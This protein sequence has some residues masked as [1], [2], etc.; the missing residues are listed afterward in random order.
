[1]RALL[2]LM[3]IGALSVMPLSGCNSSDDSKETIRP[4]ATADSPNASASP[5][6]PSSPSRIEQVRF[7]SKALDAEKT[8]SVYLP[9]SYNPDAK[10]PVLYMFYGYGGTH[11]AFFSHLKLNG[12]ADKLIREGRIDPLI[13]VSPDYGNSFAVNTKKGEGREPGGVSI[14]PYEDYLIQDL[15]PYVDSNYSTQANKEGRYVGGISMGGFA[16]LHLGFKHPDLFSR[17]GAHSAALWTYAS[18]DQYTSQRDWLYPNETL[19]EM[20][21]PFKLAD[22]EKLSGVEIYLDAGNQDLLREQDKSLYEL[23]RS[24][25]ADVQW[26]H[27]P[28]GHDASYWSKQ[29][30]AYLLFYAGKR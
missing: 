30:K 12:V 27:G 8:M 25:D 17:I 7:H 29:L 11:D 21:D 3:W 18:N 24:I 6:S 15:I 19:R 2:F 13:I 1:M 22:A 23:L 28:G 26:A 14:G 9:P 20:R 4:A 16:S 5:V 10:Y